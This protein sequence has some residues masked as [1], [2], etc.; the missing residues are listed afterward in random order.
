VNNILIVAVIVHVFSAA[1]TL[2]LA[3]TSEKRV[4]WFTYAAL[5][6]GVGIF[7]AFYLYQKQPSDA[8]FYSL[9]IS[10]IMFLLVARAFL[11]DKNQT[12]LKQKSELTKAQ[13]KEFSSQHSLW[14][15]EMD[16]DLRFTYLSEENKAVTGYDPRLYIGRKR[17][18]IAAEAKNRD[19]WVAHTADLEAHKEIK[20]YAYNLVTSNDK[21]LRIKING[22]PFYDQDGTFQGY[23][24]NG[25][26][27]TKEY[28]DQ[29]NL[30]SSQ[31]Q[32]QA[33]LDNV[34]EAVIVIDEKSKIKTFNPAAETMFGYT[35]QDI[36]GH[37]INKMMT[38]HDHDHHDQYMKDYE[39][40]GMAKI[41][42][43]REREL[44]AVRKNGEIF[45]I[46]LNIAEFF[47]G[48]KRNFIGTIRDISRRKNTE[49]K[50]R[51]SMQDVKNANQAKSEFLAALSHEF[52]TPL[53]SIIGFSELI[54][55]RYLGISDLKFYEDYVKDIHG[56][57]QHLLSLVN[58]VLDLSAIEAGKRDIDRVEIDINNCIDRAHEILHGA[59]NEKDI[60]INVDT[61]GLETPVFADQRAVMQILINLLSNA[62]KF[63]S[64]GG[65]IEVRITENNTHHT[66]IVDDSGKGIPAYKLTDLIKPFVMLE[67]NPPD[68][69]QGTGLGLAIVDQLAQLHGGSLRLES[70]VGKGT[71]VYV[72]LAKKQNDT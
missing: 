1:L 27:V 48:S 10:A 39:Q 61:D 68:G 18:E 43:V 23:R 53:N 50:L 33:I 14:F 70:E 3:F 46:E 31:Q 71:Q 35:E 66:L 29:V 11:E 36:I 7:N 4:F 17:L 34:V 9:A 58:D 42:G 59:L 32:L 67:N 38:G 63:S 62:I 45:P 40:T 2:R 5:N 69:S 60:A 6:V 65:Q 44:Q 52:R 49:N 8:H 25:R 37:S 26:D 41:L 51:Q 64:N 19:K 24:G 15:W 22:K 21:L 55:G 20:E 47:I 13:L 54:M 57:S 72:K 30:T 16:K 12:E 56:S 28:E